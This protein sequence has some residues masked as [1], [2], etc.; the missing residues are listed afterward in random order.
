[1]ESRDSLD[2]IFV[3]VEKQAVDVEIDPNSNGA[4][5]LDLS[6]NA[7]W[8]DGDDDDWG[9]FEG[10]VGPPANGTEPVV[11]EVMSETV[12]A[13][14]NGD[15][16]DASF[17][18]FQEDNA[19]AAAAAASQSQTK[20]QTQQAEDQ[21]EDQ[22]QNKEQ[23]QGQGVTSVGVSVGVLA[24][25]EADLAWKAYYGAQPSEPPSSGMPVKALV[26]K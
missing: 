5:V 4:A 8:G 17:G 13:T 2:D 10:P 11:E 9:G 22:D 25:V 16:F 15:S 19:A 23:G 14:A 24:A 7:D 6:A 1:M 21:I 18:A 20:T 3:E 12:T 26:R